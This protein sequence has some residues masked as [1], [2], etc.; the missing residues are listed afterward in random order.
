MRITKE[1]NHDGS[2]TIPFKYIEPF[3]GALPSKIE[4]Y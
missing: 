1:E 2:S 3:I 4:Q